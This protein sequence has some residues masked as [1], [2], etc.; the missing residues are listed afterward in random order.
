MTS[1][2]WYAKTGSR[3]GIPYGYFKV[4]NDTGKTISE[5]G[6]FVFDSQLKFRRDEER[7]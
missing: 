4:D 3:M 1:Y 2:T 5:F 7:W 6:K